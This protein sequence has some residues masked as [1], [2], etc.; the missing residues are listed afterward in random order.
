[1]AWGR[2][3]RK[4]LLRVAGAWLLWSSSVEAAD[5]YFGTEFTYEKAESYNSVLG[6]HV[7]LLTSYGFDYVPDNYVAPAILVSGEISRETAA[8]V[9]RLL[10]RNP[11]VGMLYLDSPGGDLF[12]GMDLGVLAHKYG[13]TV[14]VNQWGAECESACALAFLGGKQRVIFTDTEKFGFHRQYYII[15]DQIFYGSWAKDV[16]TIDQYL[17][18]IDSHAVNADEVVGTTQLVTYS[19]DRLKERGITTVTRD[20]LMGMIVTEVERVGVTQAEFY[21]TECGMGHYHCRVDPLESPVHR[22]P[23]VYLKLIADEFTLLNSR[24]V[25]VTEEAIIAQLDKEASQFEASWP[26]IHWLEDLTP[27][28]CKDPAAFAAL[29][30]QRQQY[31]SAM[32]PAGSA[33]Y[34]AAAAKSAAACQRV[35]ASSSSSGAPTATPSAAASVSAADAPAASSGTGA[36]P[37]LGGIW[38]LW[39]M[40]SGRNGAEAMFINTASITEQGPFV[41]YDDIVRLVTRL[42]GEQQQVEIAGR[43]VTN[44]EAHQM[45]S[46]SMHTRDYITGA[47]GQIQEDSEPLKWKESSDQ[48]E[49]A[50]LYHASHA[51]FTAEMSSKNDVNLRT[52]SA[53]FFMPSELRSAE[54]PTAYARAVAQINPAF[55]KAVGVSG[56]P[57]VADRVP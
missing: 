31:A 20:E 43:M 37:Y 54:G 1:M 29:M 49:A 8:T 4:I 26:T 10:E 50:C 39:Y 35:A 25:A 14:V 5:L 3:L 7:Y 27:I 13:L 18:K 52:V 44:C 55:A 22:N 24:G 36:M 51:A 45:S 41:Y 40:D 30:Q 2:R 28:D 23:G 56:G 11:R 21:G 6:G 33:S 53:E 16:R 46:V 32:N 12:A 47:R 19:Q 38:A 57:A 42:N 9:G 34:A 48:A 15:H 17:R